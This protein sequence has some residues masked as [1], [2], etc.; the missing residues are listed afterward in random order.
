MLLMLCYTLLYNGIG[1][2]YFGGLNVKGWKK[3]NLY[4][5]NCYKHNAHYAFS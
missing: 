4:T 3:R 5:D 1:M 2:Y